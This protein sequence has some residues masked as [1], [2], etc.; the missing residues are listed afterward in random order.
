[1]TTQEAPDTGSYDVVVLG[2][3]IAGIYAVYKFREMGLS[4]KAFEAASDVGGVWFWNRYPGARCDVESIDYSYSFDPELEQDWD[5]SEKYATQP[6]I[7]AYLRH[8]TDRYEL[9]PHMQFNTRITSA[10]LN[11]ENLTWTVHTD[12]GDEVT[13]RFFVMAAGP[14]SNANVPAFPGLGDFRGDVLH[15]AQWPHEGYDF[16]GKRVGLIGTGSSGIQATPHLAEDAE[17]LYVFQRTANYSIP[18]GN[19]PITDEGLKEYKANYAERRAMSWTSGGG[20]PHRPHP[21]S[22][23]DVSPEERARA[24]EERWKLGGVLFSKTFPDQLSNLEANHTAREFWENKIREVINDPEV[25][26]QLIPNDHPIGAKRICTDSD[27][28]ETFNRDNVELVNLKR[29]P[30]EGMDATGINTSEAHY[31]LDVIVL[32]TGFDAMTGSVSKVDIIGRAG[33]SLNEAWA[34]GPKT[35]LGLGV[36][37]FPNMFNLTG[38]GSPSVLANMVLHSELHVNFVA[39]LI[40]FLDERGAAG[41]EAGADAQ[42]AWVN[43]TRRLAEGSLLNMANSWYLGSNI[44]NRPR[45]FMPYAAGFSAYREVLEEVTSSQYRGFS[46]LEK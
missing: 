18:A 11:E 4:V 19:R 8:V 40:K 23:L 43:E 39:D 1:M 46:V 44:P 30:L 42:E 33:Q 41:I 24:Y 6:E 25:A 16:T 2:A 5:W 17:K 38:P 7:L 31:D 14:L 29:T 9:R 37:G 10:E 36:N 34:E 12:R 21:Q 3:G 20:S 26:E 13:A 35:Y 15:T 32:A 27:Y 22:A 45:V 28:Y